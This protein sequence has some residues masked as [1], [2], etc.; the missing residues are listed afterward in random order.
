[1]KRRINIFLLCF[2]LAAILPSAVSA[3]EPNS[4][5]EDKKKREIFDRDI[6]EHTFISKGETVLGLTA[7]YGSVVSDNSSLLYLLTGVDGSLHNTSVDPFVGYFY[8]DNRCLGL[9]FGYSK[10]GG[11]VK[12][13]KLDLGESNDMSFDIPSVAMESNSFD[14][15]IFHRSYLSL[16]RKGSFGLFAE[17]ELKARDAQSNVSYDLGGESASVRSD[18]FHLNLG[19]NPGIAVF[20]LDNVSTNVSIGLGGLGYTNITQ[21]DADGAAVGSRKTS[22]LS[23]KLNVTEI[24]FGITVHL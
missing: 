24:N 7:S 14:Y 17:F 2:V 15:A 23:L 4:G 9:R 3:A 6:P 12:G 13:G 19:F 5:R 1:M 16:D 20:V 22:K 18:S 21:F 10:L 8:K 11:A